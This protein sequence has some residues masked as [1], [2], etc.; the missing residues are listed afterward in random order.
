MNWE[1]K[2]KILIC[3]ILTAIAILLGLMSLAVK[4]ERSKMDGVKELVDDAIKVLDMAIMPA[5]ETTCLLS[6]GR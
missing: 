6:R 2:I 3:S 4:G 1:T 5:L